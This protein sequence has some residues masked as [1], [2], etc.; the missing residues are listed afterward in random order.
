MG[1]YNREESNLCETSRHG[2]GTDQQIIFKNGSYIKVVTAGDSARGKGTAGLAS[3]VGTSTPRVVREEGSGRLVDIRVPDPSGMRCRV[4]ESVMTWWESL[5]VR[6]AYGGRR[7]RVCE[8]CRVLRGMHSLDTEVV[9][10][11][12]GR[13]EERLLD[14]L[15][16]LD[17]SSRDAAGALSGLT[18]G[19]ST[20]MYSSGAVE[21]NGRLTTDADTE[22]RV[23]DD[24]WQAEEPASVGDIAGLIG[25]SSLV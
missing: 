20:V 7:A 19:L 21:V 8:S 10:D 2:D 9:E 18:C 5:A 23:S 16:V 17:V 13:L 3:R 24:K 11:E 6:D 1:S 14:S 4:C 22:R 15:G 12:P 25:G